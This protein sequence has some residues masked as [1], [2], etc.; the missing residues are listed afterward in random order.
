MVSLYKHAVYRF[1]AAGVLRLSSHAPLQGGF[2]QPQGHVQLLM[3][4]L[5]RGM[6]PQAAIDAP[7]FCIRGGQANG[8]IALEPWLPEPPRDESEG[9]GDHPTRTSYERADEA[10]A[11]E[12]RKLGHRVVVVRGHDRA[13]MG[14]AQV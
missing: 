3:H 4:M 1:L 13:E 11:E 10:V 8:V 9:G 7:R 12:L 14:R 2:M 6:E 5:V